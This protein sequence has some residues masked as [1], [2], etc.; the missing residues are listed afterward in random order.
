MFDMGMTQL[1]NKDHKIQK[2][3]YRV[4]EELCGSNSAG[5]F[6]SNHPNMSTLLNQFSID[7]LVCYSKLQC[8]ALLDFKQVFAKWLIVQFL[9][10]IIPVCREFVGTHLADI[11]K[12]LL[13]SLSKASPPSQAS[14]LRCLIHIIRQLQ[15]NHKI[16]KQ[17]S[18][19]LNK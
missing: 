11:Q 9:L 14:R 6:L 19:T 18:K 7:S 5:Q 8:F 15:V 10:F 16:K 3:S 4:L 2:R 13:T 12:N 1:A 17:Y